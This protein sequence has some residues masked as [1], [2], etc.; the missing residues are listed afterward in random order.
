MAQ[1]IVG[2]SGTVT[3]ASVGAIWINKWEVSQE[4]TEKEIGPFLG[5]TNTYVITTQRR[6]QGN[7]EA[8]VP[9]GK[10]AAQTLLLSGAI[11]GSYVSIVLATTGGYTVTV[12]SGQ[13]S[14]FN[15]SQDAADTVK[16]TFDWKSSG[17]YSIV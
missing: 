16:I 11:N 5:D 9:N 7:I 13:V 4:T 3:I 10:D 14:N 15:L 6:L 2:S 12:P 17:A 8:T 1:P